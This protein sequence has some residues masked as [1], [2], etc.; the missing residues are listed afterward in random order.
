[1]KNRKKDDIIEEVR[2]NREI[3][4]KH[5]ATNPEQ[6]HEDAQ[7]LAKKFGIK[8]SKLKPLKINIYLQKKKGA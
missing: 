3:A 8:R 2:S 5:L 4:A 7:K 1:M 6:F